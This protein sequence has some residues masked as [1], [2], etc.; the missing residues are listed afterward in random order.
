MLKSYH[1]DLAYAV[2]KYDKAW[3]IGGWRTNQ[4]GQA[5]R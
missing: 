3:T 2:A 5:G 1:F 4:D